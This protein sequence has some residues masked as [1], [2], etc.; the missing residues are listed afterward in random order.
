MTKKKKRPAKNM[1]VR[2]QV[3][4]SKFYGSIFSAGS[5]KEAEE[6]INEIKAK[7]HDATHNVSAFRVENSELN[8]DPIEYFDD[9]GEPAG[10][11]GPPV[12][13]AIKGENLINTVIIVTR[14]F[15]GTE[16]GIGGLIRAYGDT[17]RMAIKK[18]GIKVLSEFYLIKVE[19]TFNN[20]GT[21]L[22]QLESLKAEIKK[23]EYTNQGVII[24]ALIPTKIKDK[25]EIILKEKTA[26]DYSL[27]IEKSI[28]E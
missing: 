10:S 28:F 16:L 5:R 25:L 23:T 11:S 27:K 2:N 13:K 7:Y 6:R 17:A 19:T 18:A 4:D 8:Q 3:K 21:V 24:K 12:L 26:A 15:G 14:F 1:E 22:G 20:I 9:D